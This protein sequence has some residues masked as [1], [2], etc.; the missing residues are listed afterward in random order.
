MLF[1]KYRTKSFVRDRD[2]H[3]AQIQT[4]T[5]EWLQTARLYRQKTGREAENSNSFGLTLDQINLRGSGFIFT[6]SKIL[7]YFVVLWGYLFNVLTMQANKWL[8]LETEKKIF[9]RLVGMMNDE[10]YIFILS[11]DVYFC[12]KVTQRNPVSKKCLY[13]E[14][15]SSYV[16]QV[17]LELA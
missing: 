9:W 6:L 13:L 16:I 12:I 4:H 8:R 1:N 11:W 14:T 7:M 3:W 17:D 10:W 5:I 15:G 2:N